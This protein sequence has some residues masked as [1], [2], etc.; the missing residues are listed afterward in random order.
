LLHSWGTCLSWVELL[1]GFKVSGPLK[2]TYKGE[3]I[4]YEEHNH[5][6]LAENDEHLEYLVAWRLEHLVEEVGNT[7][8]VIAFI[9]EG[10]FLGLLP[11]TLVVAVCS[12]F[13]LS[14]IESSS[15]VL[16]SH[17][18]LVIR[19]HLR[20]VVFKSHSLEHAIILVDI[21]L[22][23]FLSSLIKV[24]WDLNIAEFDTMVSLDF[25][26]PHDI[27]PCLLRIV[28][29]MMSLGFNLSQD[30]QNDFRVRSHH[31]ID[32][33]NYLVWRGHHEKEHLPLVICELFVVISN[34]LQAPI[35]HIRKSNVKD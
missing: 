19:S 13:V 29:H 21:L 30:V 12:L 27:F 5:G 8:L 22:S 18:F 4:G 1:G 34:Q 35:M 25:N 11:L 6:E 7:G 16:A 23:W 17:G 2:Q 9:F 31:F 14:S 3:E 32:K 28:L 10:I 24:I 20:L 15:S 26:I 33:I